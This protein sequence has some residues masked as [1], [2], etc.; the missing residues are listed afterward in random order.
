M[1]NVAMAC[2]IGCVTALPLQVLAVDTIIVGGN[3]WQCQNRCVV[4]T[5]MN[6]Q[7]FVSD[8]LNGW[9]QMMNRRR[10]PVPQ[11][12]VPSPRRL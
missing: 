8:S 6:G 7:M 4:T 1:K 10:I 3:T 2:A 9:V 5:D 12:V 11:I